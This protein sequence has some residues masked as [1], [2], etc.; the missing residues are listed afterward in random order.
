[1][2]SA[3]PD[4]RGMDMCTLAPMK[5]CAQNLFLISLALAFSFPAYADFSGRVVSVADGDT[6]TV[7]VGRDQVKVRLIEIDAPEKAQAFGNKAK[8]A[9]ST[10]VF[11]KVVKVDERGKDRYQRTLGR[12]VVNG[13]DVNAEMVRQGYAWVYRKYS[14]N[15][16]LLQLEAEA[17]ESKA[18]LWADAKAIPPWQWRLDQK[19]PAPTG[20]T[21][22]SGA[23]RNCSEARAAGAAPVR[24]GDPGYGPHLDRDNDGIGCE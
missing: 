8:Q 3:A 9:L 6:I 1:M 18:G 21:P 16:A 10:M 15:P 20:E 19:A 22:S 24:R 14:K 17:K 12:V 4:Y 7:L 11:D 13:L 5:L 23:F 2:E